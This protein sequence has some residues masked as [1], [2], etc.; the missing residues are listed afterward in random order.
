MARNA[1]PE[2]EQI[3]TVSRDEFDEAVQSVRDEF[4]DKDHAFGE[5]STLAGP[6][7]YAVRDLAYDRT[8][9]VSSMIDFSGDLVQVRTEGG[10][11]PT[12][13]SDLLSYA[14][15]TADREVSFEAN[16]REGSFSFEFARD[17]R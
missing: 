14:R 6:V 16:V 8:G 10:E 17:D 13:V 4:A 7:A 1:T 15:R 5:K 11:F 12:W 3:T 2:D 9:Q